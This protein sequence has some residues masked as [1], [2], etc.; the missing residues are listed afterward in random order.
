MKSLSLTELSLNERTVLVVGLAREGTVAARWLAEHGARVIASDV[1]ATDS[2]GELAA[3]GVDVRLGP[4]TPELLDGADAVVAS[5][6][7]PQDLSL[8]LAANQRGIPITTE[9]RLFAQLCPAEIVGITG[10]SGK[11]TTTT[12]TAKMLEAS[13]FRTWLGGNIGEPLL[14][15]VAEMGANDRVV[16]ELSSFQLL[17]WGASAIQ[18]GAGE[19]SAGLSPHVAGILNLTPNHLDRHPSMAHYAA[20]KTNILA[21]QSAED[22][23][24]LNRDDPV[25]AAWIAEG[26]VKVEA[27]AEQEAVAFPLPGRAL[28]FGLMGQP[29][30]DGAWLDEDGWIWLRWQDKAQAVVHR[31]QI[32]LRG[33]HNLAN[34][35]AACCLAVAAGAAPAALNEIAST[36]TGVEHR[37]QL[38]RNRGGVLWVDDSI[39]TS[40]ERAVAALRSFDEPIVLLAGG[41]DK[42]LPWQGWAAIVHERARQVIVFGEAAGLI[43]SVLLPLPANSRVQAVH[44]AADMATVVSLADALSRPGDVVLLSPGGTSFDAYVDFAERGRHFR[45]LVLALSEE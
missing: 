27:G 5:P 19:S 29:A 14:G 32:R 43:K 6:G 25:T 1:K 40:P 4:Q 36:F 42:H 35:L 30:G 17:Y 28:S 3:L 41:R 37:L 21:S 31:Q 23:A 34:V 26:W 45:D 16:L 2:A 22:V 44:T 18:I 12:L 39:A 10:S 7:V 8:F 9:T 15:R 24:V 11:T 13:G 33:M 20:A 38:V